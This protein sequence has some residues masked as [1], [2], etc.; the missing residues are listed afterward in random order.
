LL[1]DYVRGSTQT[2]Q[3]LK[4]ILPELKQRGFRMVNISELMEHKKSKAIKDID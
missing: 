1:H 3:A 2:I 4:I